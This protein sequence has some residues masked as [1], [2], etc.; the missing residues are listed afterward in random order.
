MDGSGLFCSLKA[1]YP[2]FKLDVSFSIEEGELVCIIG[3]SGCGKS[4]TL[5]LITGLIQIDEGSVLLNGTDITQ[6]AVNQREIAMVF[7]DYA[8]FPHMSVEQNISYPMKLRKIKKMERREKTAALL[9]LVALSAYQKR[10]PQELSGG[11]RQRVALARALASQPK[12]LLLDEPLSALDAKLRKHLRDE[13]RRIHDETGVTTLYVTHDQE[14]AMAIADRI[15]VMSEGKIEQMG[16]GEEIYRNPSSLFVATFMG[17]GN[18]LPYGVLA[19][20]MPEYKVSGEE[21]TDQDESSQLLFFRPENVLVQDDESLPL[22][23]FLPHLAFSDAIV[24]N[25]EFS[26]THYR[27]SC[28]WEG[29]TIK[30]NT[31]R[32]PRGTHVRLG[33]INADIKVFMQGKN[34]GNLST[35]VGE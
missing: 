27:L 3:P 18:L 25:C 17:E 34:V 30:V 1:S 31:Q 2:D 6:A 24:G 9:N 15:I 10:K 26:G 16:S 23:A 5:Q 32:K 28:L 8:L 12:L 35:K 21:T 4:T 7:Q 11:E 22:P 14:E 13:I 29:H 33:I 20:C 19:K